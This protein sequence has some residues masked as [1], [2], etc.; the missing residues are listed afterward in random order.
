MEEGNLDEHQYTWWTRVE[1]SRK[2]E[3]RFRF[4]C[5]KI[6]KARW[7]SLTNTLTRGSIAEFNDR[8][9]RMPRSDHERQRSGADRKCARFPDLPE[10]TFGHKNTD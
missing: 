2:S 4:S 1:D 8:L 7:I 10:W 9:S 3:L 5:T 6:V